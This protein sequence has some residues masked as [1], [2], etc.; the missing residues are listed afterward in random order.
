MFGT[1]GVVVRRTGGVVIRSTAGVV[2]RWN[3]DVEV[4]SNVGVVVRS[5]IGGVGGIISGWDDRLYLT[6]FTTM[7]VYFASMGRGDL[8]EQ[9][10]IL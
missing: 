10:D 8:K 2:V 1:T 3:E 9:P 6:P 5:S 7:Y 4:P